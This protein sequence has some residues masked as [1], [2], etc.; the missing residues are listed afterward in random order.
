MGVCN[1]NEGAPNSGKPAK[2]S[3]PTSKPTTAAVEP[4]PVVKAEEEKPAVTKASTKSAKINDKVK[5][6]EKANGIAE[7][8]GVGNVDK[9]VAK[10]ATS[11]G[12]E[13]EKKGG[14]I[15]QTVD[16]LKK[17][18]G[19]IVEKM[20]EGAKDVAQNV[21]ENVGDAVQMADDAY[22]DSA[23]E[24]IEEIVRDLWSEMEEMDE[25]SA[26]KMATLH[27]EVKKLCKKVAKNLK[28]NAQRIG[29]KIMTNMSNF[30]NIDIKV[31]NVDFLK[32]AK[33]AGLAGGLALLLAAHAASEVLFLI[34]PM[35]VLVDAFREACDT[36][37]EVRDILSRLLKMTT[38][39]WGIMMNAVGERCRGIDGKK[40]LLGQLKTE[41]RRVL[42]VTLTMLTRVKQ[43]NNKEG[44]ESMKVLI[45]GK[46]IMEALSKGGNK[47][48]TVK[49]FMEKTK[50]RKGFHGKKFWIEMYPY[51]EPDDETLRLQ[52][53]LPLYG[54]KDLKFALHVDH[55]ESIVSE[56]MPEEPLKKQVR[57]ELEQILGKRSH[58]EEIKKK[59]WGPEK[60]VK[61]IVSFVG[62]VFTNAYYASDRKDMFLKL[63]KGLEQVLACA[64]FSSTLQVMDTVTK[65]NEI[66]QEMY[67]FHQ[68]VNQSHKKIVNKEL[69]Q[70]WANNFP[71]LQLVDIQ[72]LSPAIAKWM[73]A[74]D[75]QDKNA[76]RSTE[77]TRKDF[78]ASTVYEL[79]D[80]ILEALV[81]LDNNKGRGEAADSKVHYMEANVWFP[82]NVNLR[83][84]MKS[85]IKECRDWN[86]KY[87]KKMD[88]ELSEMRLNL[89]LMKAAI[90]EGD[91]KSVQV[92]LMCGLKIQMQRKYDKTQEIR[93]RAKNQKFQHIL[94]MH[95]RGPKT[96]QERYKV[97]VG[98][99]SMA[100]SEEKDHKN[101]PQNQEYKVAMQYLNQASLA[102]EDHKTPDA[103]A[104][105]L[106]VN[107]LWDEMDLINDTEN[108][109]EIQEL[110]MRM[111]MFGDKSQKTDAAFYMSLLFHDLHA[112]K[113]KEKKGDDKEAKKTL[114]RWIDSKEW[115]QTR[116]N[117]TTGKANQMLEVAKDTVVN[118]LQE[119]AWAEGALE[120]EQRGYIISNLAFVYAYLGDTKRKAEYLQK[121][122][123]IGDCTCLYN[124]ADHVK[125][126]DGGYEKTVELL[127]KAAEQSHVP[128]LIRLGC[129]YIEETKRKGIEQ[130][131]G[132]A[133]KYFEKA[134]KVEP[135]E[136]GRMV[137]VLR[138]LIH[139]QDMSIDSAKRRSIK[140]AREWFKTLEPTDFR[141]NLI[142]A[143]LDGN[144]SIDIPA[145][146]KTPE[147]KIKQA[148]SKPKTPETKKHVSN[149]APVILSSHG[150]KP[151][152]PT[153]ER[154]N[155]HNAFSI[156]Q[157]EDE[158]EIVEG[159]VKGAVSPSAGNEL[160][161][162]EKLKL[163]LKAGKG[164]RQM[165][166][167]MYQL[168]KTAIEQG[169]KETQIRACEKL[170]KHVDFY[171][172]FGLGYKK[173]EELLLFLVEHGKG[174]PIYAAAY[175]LAVYY[176][177]GRKGIPA[178]PMLQKKYYRLKCDEFED[179]DCKYINDKEKFHSLLTMMTCCR[180]Y[181]CDRS[182]SDQ[183]DKK[184]VKQRM[185]RVIKVKGNQMLDHIEHVAQ[186]Q[187]KSGSNTA[188]AETLGHLRLL[189]A[190]YTAVEENRWNEYEIQKRIN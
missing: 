127:N 85:Y 2:A 150:M 35:M 105:M 10:A 135:D 140:K 69:Q 60:S 114:R 102:D 31:E 74:L 44:R 129:Y 36:D 50:E 64:H 9:K 138:D 134:A 100:K 139:N 28:V 131:D 75:S 45:P 87:E 164:S 22:E 187:G 17:S 8:M 21:A 130:N 163:K 124:L 86:E 18:A 6:A 80:Q 93:A 63:E 96:H 178:N 181:I 122:A 168:L 57:E 71:H 111:S 186:V 184:I 97:A 136:F 126:K 142:E 120:I 62:N 59:Q 154:L 108:A 123:D 84:T 110:L 167:E 90:E 182:I 15:Q 25:E 55:V 3:A 112:I 11:I 189:K 171:K 162:Y 14:S 37:S 117:I 49:A 38:Q 185:F 41:V 7:D 128:S 161:K 77:V 65:N 88:E 29:T 27:G 147:A 106:L 132:L 104:I 78:E 101:L 173:M 159:E 40:G 56:E 143:R 157:E 76:Q 151:E 190:E 5:K 115:P 66:L 23:S 146:S 152:T 47:E 180:E 113:M 54:F 166:E 16:N 144:M 43:K 72:D 68:T 98:L 33:D 34:K 118:K 70:I 133:L 83:T 116:K 121:G 61:S 53:L 73:H 24:Q 183:K 67:K 1:S 145:R 19:E 148:S 172:K 170:Y 42:N 39:L 4:V 177:T 156:D 91:Q 174:T 141:R 119:L 89:E 137:E 12:K 51:A 165:I 48:K 95:K 82:E 81:F 20:K 46:H 176:K 30:A 125:G 179:N 58:V 52:A 13:A 149:Y 99:I 109:E 26:E 188:R 32:F 160:S 94:D 153:M 169:K 175:R 103:N 158:D 155:T 107:I 92:L 79:T